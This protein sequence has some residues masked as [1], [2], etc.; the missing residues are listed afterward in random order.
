M[1]MQLLIPTL[2]LS[3][4]SGCAARF[5]EMTVEQRSLRLA[6]ERAK[7]SQVTDPVAK[8]KSYI[9]IS[10][11]VLT[12]VSDALRSGATGDIPVLMEQYIAAVRG[13]RDTMVES[14]RD[15]E[16]RPGGYKDLEI[17]VRGQ[18]RAL[19]DMSRQLVFDERK[20]IEEAIA[21]ATS[22]RED[23]LRLLFPQS[24][25]SASRTRQQPNADNDETGAGYALQNYGRDIARDLSA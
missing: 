10:E 5:A 17:A 24:R 19:Q 1:K 23:M 4:T 13:G 22:V 7:I 18:L 21:A 9:A 11:I 6:S 8:T 2:C 14:R 25:P 15:A 16:R 12:F 3:L 20:P